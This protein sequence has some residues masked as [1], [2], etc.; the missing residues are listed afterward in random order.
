[1]TNVT[2][3]AA[4]TFY[5]NGPPHTDWSGALRTTYSPALSMLPKGMYY[6]EPCRTTRPLSW[7]RFTDSTHSNWSAFAGNPEGKQ[8]DILVQLSTGP[9]NDELRTAVY[10]V[11]EVGSGQQQ[12]TIDKLPADQDFYFQ[13]RPHP[14]ANFVYPYAVDVLLQS[15]TFQTSCPSG[16]SD[17]PNVVK[18]LANAGFNL[19]VMGGSDPFTGIP[20]SH[21]EIYIDL[22]NAETVQNFEFVAGGGGC[23][24][25]PEQLF[26]QSGQG[27]GYNPDIYGWQLE[28]EPLFH[29]ARKDSICH[30]GSTQCSGT[31]MQAALDR[32]TDKFNAYNDTSQVIFTVEATDYGETD[33]VAFPCDPYPYWELFAQLGDAANHDNYPSWNSPGVP[34]DTTRWIAT[35]V[36]HQTS[37]VVQ[38]KP[39]W[40]TVDAF[41]FGTNG[42]PSE[43][44]TRAVVYTAVVHGATGIWYYTWDNYAIRSAFGAGIVGVR[45]EIPPSYPENSSAPTP[46]LA[47]RNQGEALWNDIAD[48][49]AELTALE[50]VILAPTSTLK[51]KL[52]VS[53]PGQLNGPPPDN[54]P[55]SPVHTMLKSVTDDA[56]YLIAVNMEDSSSTFEFEPLGMEINTDQTTTWAYPGGAQAVTETETLIRDNLGPFQTKVYRIE[57]NPIDPPAMPNCSPVVYQVCNLPTSPSEDFDGDGCPQEAA[58]VAETVAGNQYGGELTSNASFGG[59]RDDFNRYDYLNPTLDGRNRVDDILAVVNEYFNDDPVTPAPT[60]IIDVDYD[61]LTDRTSALDPTEAWDL[62]APNGQQRVDDILAAVKQYFHDCRRLS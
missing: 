56:Q 55:T 22:K 40:F 43:A 42:F 10:T 26:S 31:N 20:I 34:F 28:D 11:D 58:D 35:S 8:Y 29:A 32:N 60:P 19:L 7:P 38:N 21:P 61:S 12:R 46:P 27:Y 9:T 17:D 50:Y 30:P 53:N 37:A 36:G 18:R 3:D 49:N 45:P 44:Q 1:M 15:G 62:A 25:F 33:H 48:I 57:Y 16:D 6:P 51:Y 39:S 13:I 47:I 2:K 41:S 14:Y 52:S 59:R 23:Q 5:Y 24:D 54:L 4:Q